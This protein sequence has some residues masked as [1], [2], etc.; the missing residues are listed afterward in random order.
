MQNLKV[1][2]V[3]SEQYW[4]DKTKN[5]AHFDLLLKDIHETDL[6]ILP[7]MFHT[8]FSMRASELAEEMH[9]SMGINWLKNQAITKNVAIY[10]SLII[11]EDGLYYN[12]GIFVFPSGEFETYD[13]IK[14]FSLA[15]EDTVFTSGLA[16]T[17]LTYKGWNIMLQICYDLRFPEISRN[18]IDF[19]NQQP[20]YDVLLY[21]AN[22]PTRRDLHWR[23]LLQARAI[24]NQSYVIGVNRVGKDG[25][26]LNYCGSS[27]CVSAL[28]EIQLVNSLGIEQFVTLELVKEELDEIRM[29]IPFLK[30]YKC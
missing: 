5:L 19:S 23:T 11:Q 10:T 16:P 24:E 28:G 7:E 27:M 12:R 1:T 15:G 2:L 21:V 25:N 22:W 8:S 6:I 29:K 30:D 14:L 26:Q 3:Q 18:K 4:E 9:D 20:I 13:K 17:I